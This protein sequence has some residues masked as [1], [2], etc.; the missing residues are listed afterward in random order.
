MNMQSF[1]K[2]I[3]LVVLFSMVL[4]TLPNSVFADDE[5]IDYNELHQ[6]VLQ[7]IEETSV[8]DFEV[9]KS[10]GLSYKEK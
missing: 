7:G 2:S 10:I 9:E 3:I 6:K 8:M 4:F 1:C 5:T